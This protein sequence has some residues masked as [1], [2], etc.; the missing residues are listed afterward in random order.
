MTES[1]TVS[2]FTAT[3][4]AEGGNTYTTGSVSGNT[5][6]QVC[7]KIHSTAHN[8]RS[9][10]RISIGST[11]SCR[12]WIG[13]SEGTLVNMLDSDTPSK[14]YLAFRFSTAA[15]DSNWKCITDNG[16]GSP[17]IKDSGVA[18]AAGEYIL[19]ILHNTPL[20]TT[21]FFINRLAASGDPFLVANIIATI[22]SAATLIGQMAGIET[23]AAAT[24]NFSV[25]YMNSRS[26]VV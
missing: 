21:S 19:G 12:L 25:H 3:S 15:G 14:N 17:T 9:V 6:G 26:R 2:T 18:V 5:S 8:L 1:G 22:P 23:L 16:T 20:N 7:D 11:T 13:Y 24:K 10:W 4:S